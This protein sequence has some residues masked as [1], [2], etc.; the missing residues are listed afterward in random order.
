MS[1]R[2][3]TYRVRLIGAPPH[4]V[5]AATDRITGDVVSWDRAPRTT[6]VHELIHLLVASR[7]QRELD[8]EEAA[9]ES[10]ITHLLDV[11][12]PAMRSALLAPI[13][14]TKGNNIMDSV[15]NIHNGHVSACGCGGS[16]M[17]ANA[18]GLQDSIGQC[19]PQDALKLLLLGIKLGAGIATVPERVAG[20]GLLNAL[21]SASAPNAQRSALV[22]HL[23][24]QIRGA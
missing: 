13:I 16:A 3:W 14:D 4:G 8:G 12:P 10:T 19:T 9:I 5:L 15:C 18:P 7:H 2:S 11:S 24:S 20:I 17:S 23:I 6:L 22:A 21:N 1:D